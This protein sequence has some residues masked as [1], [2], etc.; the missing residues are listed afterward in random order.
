MS[1]KRFLDK[2]GVKTLWDAIK[3]NFRTK[4]SIVPIECGGTGASDK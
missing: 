2:T 1:E 3:E 4:T